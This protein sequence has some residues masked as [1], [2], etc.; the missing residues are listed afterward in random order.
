MY[1]QL[2][3]LDGS[4]ANCIKRISDGAIIPFDPANTDFVEYNKWLALGNQPEPAET[5]E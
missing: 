1:K 5:T 2:K 3:N 4:I